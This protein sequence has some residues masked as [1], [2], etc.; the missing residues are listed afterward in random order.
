MKK[1]SEILDLL[2]IEI[3]M[4]EADHSWHRIIY[5]SMAGNMDINYLSSLLDGG[6]FPSI[7]TV[8]A[9][10][11]TPF[12]SVKFVLFGE[13]PY[14]RVGSAIGL[15]FIDGEVSELWSEQGLSKKVNKATSLRN[16]IKTALVAE[17]LI[18]KH[19]TKDDIA[20]L[21]KSN[22]SKTMKD[23]E[24][25]FISSGFLLLN[26]SPILRENKSKKTIKNDFLQWSGFYSKILKELDLRDSASDSSIVLWG[27]IAKDIESIYNPVFM[28][29]IKME[30]PYNISF[31]SN[32]MA[33]DLFSKISI[34]KRR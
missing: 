6:F 5:E 22:L 7:R 26:A 8:F 30:H 33:I 4:S 12:Y 14:P 28:K 19:F 20:K 13:S 9:P 3:E 1:E 29:Y 15:S 34:M 24:G 10:F 17:G 18:D 2:K 25:S 32:Q 11:K 23:I 16:I 21:D 31:I 27:G